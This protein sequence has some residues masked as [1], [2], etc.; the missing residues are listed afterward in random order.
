MCCTPLSGYKEKFTKVDNEK[1]LKEAEVIEGGYLELGFTLF[2]KSTIEYDVK[3]ES[4]ANASYVTID[5][6]AKIAELAKNYFIK[7]KTAKE[8]H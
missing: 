4:A 7:N 5:A 3:E 1:R 6:V 2:L 8:A